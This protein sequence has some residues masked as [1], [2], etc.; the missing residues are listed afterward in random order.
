MWQDGS[1]TWHALSD[2]KNFFPVQLAEYAIHNKLENEPVFWWWI[3]STMH[4]KEHFLKAVKS[5]YSKRTHKFGIRVPATVEEAWE[6]DKQANALFW[7]YAIQKEMQNCRTAFKFLEVDEAIPIGY[8]WI[9]CHL[10]FDV[11]MD[12]TRGARFVAGGHM[13]NPLQKLLTL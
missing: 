1:T 5:R 11:K 13:T 12:F 8:K 4:H 7:H 3:K 10:I 6:T 9:K 2:I